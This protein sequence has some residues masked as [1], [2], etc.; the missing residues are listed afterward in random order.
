MKVGLKKIIPLTIVSCFCTVFLRVIQITKITET[1]TGFFLREHAFLGNLVTVAIFVF[2][3]IS[4]I[5]SAFYKEKIAHPVTITKP[6]AV[7]HFLL[8]A[9]IIYESLFADVSQMIYTWQILLQIIFG[10]LSALAFATSGFYAFSGKKSAPIAMVAHIAFFLTRVIIVFSTYISV[11]TIAENVFEMAALCTALIFFLNAASLENEIDPERFQK[12]IL[13][14]AVA[15]FIMGACYSASQL[16]VMLSGKGEMLHSQTVT[17]F[18]NIVLIIYIFYYTILAFCPPKQR[19][20]P[21][22]E[23]EEAEQLNM[24]DDEI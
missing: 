1:Q 24:F 16:V 19:G 20:E 2:A 3:A 15:A 18:T 14:S 17:F 13:P 6:F 21:Q 11:S 12:R 4:V 8:A 7:L 10:I 5:Y 9:A 23:Q 22:A